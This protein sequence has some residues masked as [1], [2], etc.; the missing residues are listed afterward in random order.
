MYVRYAMYSVLLDVD[1]STVSNLCSGLFIISTNWMVVF[2][3]IAAQTLLMAPLQALVGINARKLQKQVQKVRDRRMEVVNEVFGAMKIIK[4]YAWEMSF[5][6]K[7]SNIRNEELAILRCYVWWYTVMIL[8][9]GWAPT[10]VSLTAFM[11]YTAN[12]GSLNAEKAFTSIALFNLLRFP[13]AMLPMVTISFIDSNNSLR[14]IREFLSANEIDPNI[15]EYTKIEGNKSYQTKLKKGNPVNNTQLLGNSSF[16]E[17]PIEIEQ[18]EDY[19]DEKEGNGKSPAIRI[20][21]AT[22]TWDDEMNQAALV[23]INLQFK[24]GTTTMVIGETGSG[25]S[26]L[27]R[28]ILGNLTKAN[29]RIIYGNH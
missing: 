9:W 18:K 1:I 25:K 19:D 6:N 4:M 29:G 20:E 22:F 14:R 2:I 17:E 28:A 21:N 8:F 12:G 3:G 13:L 15:I 26:A 10:L 7:I 27:L 23:D 16:N 5:G 24:H 11:A